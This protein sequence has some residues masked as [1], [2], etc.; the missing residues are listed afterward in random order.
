MKKTNK[1]FTKILRTFNVKVF[2]YL[3]HPSPT[4]QMFLT[5]NGKTAEF[6]NIFSP[7]TVLP[8]FHA[9]SSVIKLAQSMLT[10]RVIAFRD[11]NRR[12]VKINVF[13]AHISVL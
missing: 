10:E 1:L 5:L 3:V 6:A 8:E 7:E 12:C 11:G 4:E 13:R 2:E 9:F